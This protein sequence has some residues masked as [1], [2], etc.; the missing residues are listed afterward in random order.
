M[1]PTRSLIQLALVAL[2]MLAGAGRARAQDIFGTSP[3]ELTGSHASLDG[4]SN[5]GTCHTSGKELSKD[6]CLGCH[7]HWDLRTRIDSG[8]GFHSSDKVGS[9][10]CWLC[11]S[12]HKGRSFDPMGWGTIGGRA[13]FNHDWTGWPLEGKHQATGC[14][15]C[16]KRK[17]RQGIRVYLGE[18]K[19]CGSCHKDPHNFSDGPMK[20][21]ERCH[22]QDAW[23]PQ[24]KP[25]GFDHNDTKD[26]K[27]A[28]RG[29]HA[30]VACAKCHPKSEFNLKKDVSD[31]KGCHA[32]ESPHK[33][34]LFDQRGCD[35]CHA[36]DA[37]W[38]KYD[39]DHNRR[40]K[41]RLDGAHAGKDCYGCHKKNSITKP[42]RACESC[43]AKDDQHKGRFDK[44]G[45]CGG[46]HGTRDFKSDQSRFDHGKRTSFVLQAKHAVI[47]CRKCHR[48][49]SPDDFERFDPG[50]RKDCM[51][52]HQ[53][54]KVHDKQFKSSECLN[55]HLKPGERKFT[56]EAAK[57]F[58]GPDSEFPLTDSHAN[59]KCEQCHKE[60]DRF[61]DQTPNCG[62]NCHKDRL[63]KGSLGP[64]CTRCHE[65]G[66]WDPT[67]FDHDKDS[68]YKLIGL[69]KKAD[70]FACHPK[71][72]FKPT[73]TACVSCH[74]ED[75]AHAGS[76]GKRCE[77]CHSETGA[78]VFV[79]KPLASHNKL[80][81]FKL[82][83][84]HT[85]TECSECHATLKFKPTKQTCFGCHPEPDVHRGRF[86]TR[87]EGCHD[88][89]AFNRIK[90]IHDVGN[91]SLTGSHD[92]LPCA[93]CHKDKRPL[94][95]TGNL[96][97]T[98][99]RSDDIHANSLGP[100]CGECH[101]Q[102]GFAPAR[103]DHSSVGCNLRGVHRTLP[104]MDCHK[105]G[106][107]M[108]LSPACG[109]CHLN[110]ARA[111]KLGG[112][113]IDHTG[114]TE[115]AGC[116]NTSFFAPSRPSGRESVCR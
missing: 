8:K 93:R 73:P 31:C 62:E 102:W 33:G 79:D 52:C 21:C 90:P 54:E 75:D 67:K 95:G 19:T 63:H 46:C 48:G 88:A 20:N 17:N 104:C 80:S 69:H 55:C 2:V 51:G 13:N 26:A 71:R 11:H 25:L 7:D 70:C 45:D 96:C 43:H 72:Q 24:K 109:S 103:F 89:V 5:C 60:A 105:A 4:S 57:T 9:K 83:G 98:C 10:S 23:R 111:V 81:A 85:T 1:R 37:D 64:E 78:N 29:S 112:A 38:K 82:E 56:N 94:A 16:H 100:K 61:D 22:T 15:D 3:G 86:G 41:F 97:I 39:F 92:Q 76:L 14:D 49:R 77:T 36:D 32:D 99:H 6:K 30:D 91:F 58:H 87:C 106:N 53:H 108:G 66:V 27:F 65:G 68:D 40:T 84:A 18:S 59:L 34:M 107:F 74:A 42:N 101:T 28:L 115:C 47:P 116:H 114:L 50:L 12:E 44:M 110:D 35:Q 113:R